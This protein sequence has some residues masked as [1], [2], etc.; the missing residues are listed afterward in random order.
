[1]IF[2]LNMMRFNVNFVLQQ[3]RERESICLSLLPIDGDLHLKLGFHARSN[4]YGCLMENKFK[5]RASTDGINSV[6]I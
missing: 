2:V 6:N 1:M 3:Q 5:T 4:L